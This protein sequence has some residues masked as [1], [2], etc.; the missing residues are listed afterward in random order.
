MNHFKH[1][2]LI[3]TAS[4][5]LSSRSDG[6]PLPTEDEARSVLKIGVSEGAV[7]NRFGTP[8]IHERLDSGLDE[9]DYVLPPY[10]LPIKAHFAYAGFTANFKDGKLVSFTIVHASRHHI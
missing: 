4:V 2:L 7:I 3:A 1:A 6:T 8:T 10:E 5:C 9:I